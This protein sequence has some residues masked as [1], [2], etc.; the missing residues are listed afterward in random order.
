MSHTIDPHSDVANAI[1]TYCATGDVAGIR[2]IGQ[3]TYTIVRTYEYAGW[4]VVCENDYGQRNI[5]QFGME[6]EVYNYLDGLPDDSP[7]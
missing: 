5:F 6:H 4:F 2:V 3:V 7:Q 1:L